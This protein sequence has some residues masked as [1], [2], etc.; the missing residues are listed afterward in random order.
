VKFERVQACAAVNEVIRR[1]N[2]P[3]RYDEWIQ[4]Q[5]SE[6]LWRGTLSREYPGLLTEW[7]VE[8]LHNRL[9]GYPPFRLTFRDAVTRLG[10]VSGSDLTG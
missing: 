5:R 8:F 1:F 10:A 3:S 2:E 6:R 4:H 7:E 9:G